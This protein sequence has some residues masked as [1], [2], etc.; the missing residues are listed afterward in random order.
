MAPPWTAPIG[1]WSAP[2]RTRRTRRRS[3]ATDLSSAMARAAYTAIRRTGQNLGQACVGQTPH[4]IT[5]PPAPHSCQ[6]NASAK[7]CVLDASDTTRF[8][9]RSTDGAPALA[10]AGQGKRRPFVRR[11]KDRRRCRQESPRRS[12]WRARRDV[13]VR[14]VADTWRAAVIDGV[15][16]GGMSPGFHAL[17]PGSGRR[18][19]GVMMNANVA[20]TATP[21]RSARIE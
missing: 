12:I 20:P 18:S 14:F 2:K 7:L 9:R 21:W 1:G 11:R 17:D 19:A 6:R 5:V 16:V 8:R 10:D 13:G 3:N 15:L 4:R